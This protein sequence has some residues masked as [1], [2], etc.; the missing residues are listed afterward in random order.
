MI[1]PLLFLAVLILPFWGAVA[2]YRDMEKARSAG[3]L[4]LSFV[5][6]FA[7]SMHFYNTDAVAKLLPPFF[8]YPRLSIFLVGIIEFIVAFGLIFKRYRRKFGWFAVFLF[9]LF[10]PF[11]IYGAFQYAEFTGHS[12][13]FKYLF[14]RIPL[15]FI[16]ILWTWWFCITDRKY[17]EED[18]HIASC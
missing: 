16:F 3:A 7:G 13:G 8:P 2:Y 5:F 12:L 14:A 9:L 18:P 17:K 6:L 15:Q 1:T 4:G 11:N 10:L